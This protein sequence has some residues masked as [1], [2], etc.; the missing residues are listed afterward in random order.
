M[1]PQGNRGCFICTLHGSPGEQRPFQ[2]SAPYMVPQ[3]NRGCFICTLH[4]SPGEQRLFHLHP[5]WFPRG[6]EAVSSALYMVP[7]GNRGCFI[8]TLHGSPGEQRL[9]HLH[10]TWFLRGTEAVSSAPYT[11][12]SCRV[13]SIILQT[14]NNTASIFN[15]MTLTNVYLERFVSPEHRCSEK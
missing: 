10:P 9:F 7:Q 13:F 3:G 15:N 14:K 4:G 6:T 2:I 12:S 5:T 11:V 8:C 1:V